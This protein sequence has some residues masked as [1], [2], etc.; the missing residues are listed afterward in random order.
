MQYL[1]PDNLDRIVNHL[2][3]HAPLASVGLAGQMGI[4]LFFHELLSLKNDILLKEYVDNL[5]TNLLSSLSTDIPK[6]MKDGLAGLGVGISVLLA[7]RILDK[8]EDDPFEEL[9]QFLLEGFVENKDDYFIDKLVYILHSAENSSTL[10]NFDIKNIEHQLLELLQRKK[11]ISSDPYQLVLVHQCIIKLNS[12]YP[13]FCSDNLIIKTLRHLTDRKRLNSKVIEPYLGIFEFQ[14]SKIIEYKYLDRET[15]KHGLEIVRR[16]KEIR[17]ISSN[18]SKL[19]QFG[20][21]QQYKSS[22]GYPLEFEKGLNVTLIEKELD[23]NIHYNNIPLLLQLGCILIS[24]QEDN[25]PTP[26]YFNTDKGNVVMML[27]TVDA[28]NY[29]IGTYISTLKANF[30]TESSQLHLVYIKKNY[31]EFK[32]WTDNSGIYGYEIPWLLISRRSP[33]LE[34]R[35]LQSIDF[36]LER[37]WKSLNNIIIQVNYTAAFQYSRKLVEKYQCKV[38]SVVHFFSWQILLDG[39]I[40][41]FHRIWE[42]RNLSD[43]K[44]QH[45][46]TIVAV[47]QN[48]LEIYRLSDSVVVLNQFMYNM[49]VNCY[50][51]SK[52]KVTLIRN[53]IQLPKIARINKTKLREKLLFSPDDRIILFS[54]RVNHQKGVDKLILAFRK[55]LNQ[56]KNIKLV[57]AGSQQGDQYLNMCKGIW[58]RV[59]FTGHV[60]R[61]TMYKFYASADVCV[62]PSLFEA[63]SYTAL[64]MMSQRL[65]LV[66]T[67]AIGLNEMFKDEF[68]ALFIEVKSTKSGAPFVNYNSL[69]EKLKI[70]LNDRK[71]AKYIADNAYS[72][73]K[74]RHDVG[75]M[76]EKM[77][78]VYMLN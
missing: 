47:T 10:G 67:D 62:I 42:K 9:N 49:L 43:N 6:G 1:K 76:M 54:G 53:G 19:M 27:P 14:I 18:H 56:D 12:I 78:K 50:G 39:N 33:N 65:P 28:M 32:V 4:I 3:L 68:D 2:A 45:E 31:K 52:E 58:A 26:A 25:N 66:V 5:L 7:K 40:E 11:I 46:K 15:E 20:N 72:T 63:C 30:P 73:V 77:E 35:V 23:N 22:F 51:I 38:I 60:D 44:G 70:L 17:S 59:V 37:L 41:R 13:S 29:G 69:Y 64:E 74:D 55:L 36:L 21:L 61:A 8:D 16:I 57:I 71:K 48:E 75:E 34:N 24:L